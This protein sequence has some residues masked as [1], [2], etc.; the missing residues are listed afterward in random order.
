MKRA[1]PYLGQSKTVLI[2]IFELNKID[3]LRVGR[4]MMY[5]GPRPQ[6]KPD[7]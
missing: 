5:I 6:V 3:K 7:L 1:N 4:F 2:S